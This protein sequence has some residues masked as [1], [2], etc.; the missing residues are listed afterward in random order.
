MPA[1]SSTSH[2]E[3]S[4]LPDHLQPVRFSLQ[5]PKT[6]A[7]VL[8]RPLSHCVRSNFYIKTCFSGSPLTDIL[9]KEGSKYFPS[10]LLDCIT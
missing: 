3:S 1:G 10:S 2:L 7:V 5:D 9:G 4:S 6:K 8:L